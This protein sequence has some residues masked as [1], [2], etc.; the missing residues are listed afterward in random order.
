MHVT[1]GFDRKSRS[2]EEEINE[3][4]DLVWYRYGVKNR[5]E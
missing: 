2:Y 3:H 4:R 1:F 5:K